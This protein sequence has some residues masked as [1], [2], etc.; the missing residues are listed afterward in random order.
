MH[1][2]SQQIVAVPVGDINGIGD[3]IVKELRAGDGIRIVVGSQVDDKEAQ[4]FALLADQIPGRRI[5][6]IVVLANNRFDA[7]TGRI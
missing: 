5:R 1:D 7:A 3:I 4:N 2:G 6:E